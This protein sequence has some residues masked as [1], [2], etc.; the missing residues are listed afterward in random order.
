MSD[1]AHQAYLS[2]RYLPELDGLRALSALMVVAI[3]MAAFQAA[4]WQWLAGGRGVKI[5]FVLS[6]YLITTLGLREE[7]ERGGVSLAAFYVRRCCRLFP[8]YFLVLAVYYLLVFTQ[9]THAHLRPAMTAALPY[10]VFYQ[11][12]VLLCGNQAAGDF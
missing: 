9:T 5:F 12:E 1:A 6:G 3:H 10:F 8:L 7:D 4:L 11:Q 2:R